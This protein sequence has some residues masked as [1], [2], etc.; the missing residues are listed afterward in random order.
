MSYTPSGY[1]TFDSEPINPAIDMAYNFLDVV[2]EEFKAAHYLVERN[3]VTITIGRG[4]KDPICAH[5]I[6]GNG[7]DSGV[8]T[9]EGE[10]PYSLNIPHSAC[11]DME[12]VWWWVVEGACHIVAAEKNI[13]ACSKGGRHNEKF[14]RIVED[15]RCKANDH[16]VDPILG[17]G[18]KDRRGWMLR[19]INPALWARVVA[20]YNPH[21]GAFNNFYEKVEKGGTKRSGGTRSNWIC[22]TGC[23]V[24]RISLSSGLD[25]SKQWCGQCETYRTKEVM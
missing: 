10:T 13:K 11:K 5:E 1:T 21:I 19:E 15:I 18:V 3:A 9:Q 7:T 25:G 8:R 14:K 17:A 22:T 20:T 6:G 16:Y 2:L 24:F 4:G 23:D 12:T